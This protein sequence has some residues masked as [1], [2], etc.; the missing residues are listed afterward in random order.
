MAVIRPLLKYHGGKWLLAPWI[1]SYMPEHKVYVEPFGGGGSVLL[2]KSRAHEEIYNDLDREIVNL[3]RIVRDRGGELK[4][5]LE[6]T[7]YSR[8]EFELSYE[9]TDDP[10]EKARRTVVRSFMGR[11]PSSTTQAAG[12]FKAKQV[13]SYITIAH[14]WMK[15]PDAL[16][17]ITERLR[18]VIIENDNALDVIKRHDSEGTAFYVDPPYLPSTRDAGTDYRHEM[19]EEDHI[20]LAEALNRVKGKVVL[21]GY[22]S[23]LYTSLYKGWERIEKDSIADGHLPRKE[24]LWLQNI[25]IG[26]FGFGA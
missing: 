15:Y 22:P 13:K 23:E 8:D 12:S 2:R 10:I 5:K 24:V 26:I 6:F 11:N 4:K 25:E 14:V 21:S 16:N 9:P 1:L 17:S 7:P 20:R 18:G 19:T 3:F